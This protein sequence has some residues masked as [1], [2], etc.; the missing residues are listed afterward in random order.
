MGGFL[1]VGVLFIIIL[2]IPGRRE[3]TSYDVQLHI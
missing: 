3:A 1:S 2:V